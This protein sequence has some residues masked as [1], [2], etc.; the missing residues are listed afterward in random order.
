MLS[1]TVI[2]QSPAAILAKAGGFVEG[3]AS[4]VGQLVVIAYRSG[5]H[6][7]L[8]ALKCHNRCVFKHIAYLVATL[9]MHDQAIL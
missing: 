4:H 2:R 5:L 3:E 9:Q 8:V 7:Q 1:L 6:M